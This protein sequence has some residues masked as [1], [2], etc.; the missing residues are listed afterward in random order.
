MAAPEPGYAVPDADNDVRDDGR[1]PLLA[2]FPTDAQFFAETQRGSVP[3]AFLRENQLYEP[4]TL[5][6]VRMQ[7]KMINSSLL[8]ADVY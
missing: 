6:P 4:T 2:R 3:G 7:Q 1:Q 5:A 8:C